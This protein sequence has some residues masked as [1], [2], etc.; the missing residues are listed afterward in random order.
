MLNQA[1]FLKRILVFQLNLSRLELAF[2]L[3]LT[4]TTLHIFLFV[5][6]TGNLQALIWF[7]AL[8]V[9][10]LLDFMTKCMTDPVPR[11]GIK[12]EQGAMWPCCGVD[13]ILQWPPGLLKARGHA[14]W[15]LYAV[16]AGL[17]SPRG[18][19]IY[20][21]LSLPLHLLCRNESIYLHPNCPKYIS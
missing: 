11:P 17:Q 14:L 6:L 20:M 7:S 21:P 12:W 16:G 19:F 1:L 13:E 3:L 18:A 9:P 8:N 15:R 4:C 2:T 10:I 5:Y